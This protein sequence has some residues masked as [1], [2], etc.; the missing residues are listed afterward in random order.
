M[1]VIVE[2]KLRETGVMLDKASKPYDKLCTFLA[3]DLDKVSKLIELRMQS[4]HAPLI[5]DI[6]SHLISSGGK[7]LRPL[8]TLASGQLCGYKGSRIIKLAA[9]VEF[10]HTA[11]LLHDDVVDESDKRRGKSSVNILWDNSSSVLV[12]DYLFARSFQLMTEVGRLD[13]LEVLSDA[14]AKIAE[15]EV[16]QLTAAENIATSEEVYY[17]IVK[18]KTA[19]LF[20][21]SLEVGAMLADA[22]PK[23]RASLY[24]YGDALGTSFQIADDILDFV[25]NDEQVGKNVGDDF[26]ER[27][28]T[29][30]IIH[31]ISRASE[32]ELEF[33][34]RT[35]EDGDQDK[36]DFDDALRILNET[37]SIDYAKKTAINLSQKAKETLSILPNSY[38]KKT[39]IELADYVVLRIN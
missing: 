32:R 8:L 15:G 26:R 33:W 14:S 16:L 24:E 4:E 21:A 28:L 17:K 38:L 10:I 30:P 3:N 20:A 39:L 27:K 31:A 12:G 13:I 7:R 22:D 34:R 36:N 35:L 37:S 11:T 25:G 29:L 19:A 1:V 23:I 2:C 5:S 6:S 18:G 9:T